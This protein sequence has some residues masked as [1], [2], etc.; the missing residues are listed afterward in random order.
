[1]KQDLNEIIEQYDGPRDWPKVAE[2]LHILFKEIE[3]TD[4]PSIEEI[5]THYFA[6]QKKSVD[7]AIYN[8]MIRSAQ[9]ADRCGLEDFGTQTIPRHDKAA[10]HTYDHFRE[11][12]I[13][14][15]V[16]I[17]IW[18]K[19]IESNKIDGP[20]ITPAIA[21][22]M[23]GAMASHDYR[24]SLGWAEPLCAMELRAMRCVV[25]DARAVGMVDADIIDCLNA[26][27]GTIPF[28]GMNPHRLWPVKDSVTGEKMEVGSFDYVSDL[29]AADDALSTVRCFQE[30]L[31]AIHRGKN[32]MGLVIA[33]I[34][35]AADV[36]SIFLNIPKVFETNNLRDT[37]EKLPPKKR[38]NFKPTALERV[39]NCLG[40]LNFVGGVP[41]RMDLLTN[42]AFRRLLEHYKWE[43]LCLTYNAPKVAVLAP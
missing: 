16:F 9:R 20:L 29:V 6:D 43:K 41:A 11:A 19:A 4:K 14:T 15:I 23:V 2:A 36:L 7:S 35:T 21:M 1:M 25:E 10:Y 28:I 3:G 32:E 38:Q 18:N 17:G 34:A 39:E 26:V 8:F 12:V 22:K 24:R 31:R 5:V 40:F 27:A 42:Y 33:Q 13:G 37:K 30:N